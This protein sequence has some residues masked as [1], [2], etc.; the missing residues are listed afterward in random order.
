MDGERGYMGGQ[1]YED[2][3]KIGRRMEGCVKEWMDGLVDGRTNQ[4]ATN[5]RRGKALRKRGPNT[6]PLG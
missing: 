2:G 4:S 6:S 1:I 3:W 5:P